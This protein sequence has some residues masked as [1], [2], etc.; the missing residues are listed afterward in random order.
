[1]SQVIDRAIGLE[2][3][4]DHRHRRSWLTNCIQAW[5][6]LK[7]AGCPSHFS[8][9]AAQVQ[10]LASLKGSGETKLASCMQ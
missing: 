9:S 6:Q 1:V 8:T 2:G 3:R 5:A 10:V 4:S 7:Q